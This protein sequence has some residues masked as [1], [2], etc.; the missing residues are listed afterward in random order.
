M[1]FGATWCSLRRSRPL[2]LRDHRVLRT[3]SVLKKLR[4]SSHRPW[5][6]RT[7]PSR[8]R[9][10]NRPQSQPQPWSCPPIHTTVWTDAP[11]PYRIIRMNEAE[12]RAE[13]IDPAL[14][15]AGWGV[16]EGSRIRREYPS[17]SAACRAR[18]ARQAQDIA[19]YVLVY[20]NHKLAVIEAKAAGPARY[21][22]RRPGEELRRRS[23]RS[24]SPTPPT[25]RASTASTWQTGAE[26]DVAA[27]PDPG[28]TLEPRPSPRQNAWRD[29]FAAVPFED[30]G[31]Y[32]AG[33]LLPGHR[34]RARAGGHRRRTATASC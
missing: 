34:H 3:S 16:V 5:P 23:W 27:Y 6:G 10:L 28:R 33:A 1:A 11:F 9:A 22:R 13:H 4:R 26:G 31:G 2:L 19:D 18:A 21:R 32:L 12:T 30:K 14:K 29:R 25:A 7:A 8:R 15:A 20:R 24:A 17:R